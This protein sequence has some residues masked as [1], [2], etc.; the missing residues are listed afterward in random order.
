M[1]DEALSRLPDAHT[2]MIRRIGG[3]NLDV[4]SGPEDE[5]SGLAGFLVSVRRLA[6]EE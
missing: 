3:K 5:T 2:E 6:Q 4:E 1:I